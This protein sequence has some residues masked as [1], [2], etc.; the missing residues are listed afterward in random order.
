M[1]AKMQQMELADNSFLR[2]CYWGECL[3]CL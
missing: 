2:I 3:W 1:K